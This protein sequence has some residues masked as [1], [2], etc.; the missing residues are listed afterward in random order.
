MEL[1]RFHRVM[2]P[3]LMGQ[4]QAADVERDLGAPVDAGLAF[5][6][7]LAERNRF[8]ILA[9]LFPSV[10][11]LLLQRRAGLW[12][13]IVEAYSAEHPPGHPDPNRFGEHFAAFLGGLEGEI[14][15]DGLAT[16]LVQGLA[17]YCWIRHCANTSPP[18]ADD[19]FDKRLFIR[20]YDFPIVDYTKRLADDPSAP[21]PAAG[22]EFV[23]VYRDPQTLT[24]RVFR[25][26]ALG[27]AAAARRQGVAL[28][29]AWASLDA[30]AIDRA[31][32]QLL[33]RGVF[34]GTPEA[35]GGP[36]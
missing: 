27:L 35:H 29:E 6:R 32:R 5:Y 13:S 1:R 21:P 30:G 18:V 28:P 17:D 10:R 16:P 12:R 7:E 19:G 8:K 31:E 11:S 22:G 36:R 4:T 14:D 23:M 20:H 2:K 26:N 34:L 9:D 3:F 25:P 33:D 15:L 24:I